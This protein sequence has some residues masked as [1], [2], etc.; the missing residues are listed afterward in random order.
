MIINRVLRNLIN[1]KLFRREIAVFDVKIFKRVI[2]NIK[3]RAQ[4][5]IV[6]NKNNGGHFE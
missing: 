5:C 1:L 2:L 4:K 3:A 6:N